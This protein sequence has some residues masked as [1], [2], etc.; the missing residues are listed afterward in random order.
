[1]TITNEDFLRRYTALVASE[2]Y[3][4]LYRLLSPEELAAAPAWARGARTS[5][6]R[7]L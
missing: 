6:Y 5:S 4:Y 2:Q 3:V 1:M 7:K